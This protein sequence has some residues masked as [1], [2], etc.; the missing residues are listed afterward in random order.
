[1]CRL[2]DR[3]L[4]LIDWRITGEMQVAQLADQTACQRLLEDIW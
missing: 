2:A 3:A 1:M 4:V